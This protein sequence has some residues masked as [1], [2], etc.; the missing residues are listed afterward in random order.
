MRS[1]SLCHKKLAM[2]CVDTLNTSSSTA[3]LFKLVLLAHG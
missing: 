2:K 3:T 1:I